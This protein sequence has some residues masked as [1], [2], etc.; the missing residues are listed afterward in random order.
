MVSLIRQKKDPV[1]RQIAEAVTETLPAASVSQTI[2]LMAAALEAEPDGVALAA[3]QIGIAKK[4]FIVSP[5]VFVSPENG[6]ENKKRETEKKMLVFINPQIVKK[7][8]RQIDL[9][10]GCLSVRGVYGHVKRY[11]KVTVAAQDENGVPFT[12]HT[13]RLLAQVM[14]HEIDHLNG[15]LFI[16]HGY[17]FSEVK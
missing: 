13:A 12:R 6:S 2:K 17:D 15:I 14:Q 8:H 4:I 11:A 3:P 1:L 10:E 5:K 16:D 7:S 9:I